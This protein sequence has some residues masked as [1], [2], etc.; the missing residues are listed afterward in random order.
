MKFKYILLLIVTFVINFLLVTVL[1]FKCPWRRIFN[2][3]CA[4]CGVTRMLKSIISLDLY[5]AF[6]YNPVMFIFL[7]LSFIYIIC[8]IISKIIKKSFFV[9]DLKCFLFMIVIMVLF[10]I[11]RN[12][13]TFDF[14]A[15]TDI[16]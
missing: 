14:L 15:P 2:I 6:R 13:K 10:M 8:I 11:L 9:P 1:N 5:Q 7:V 4:G 12:T 3:H 16:N